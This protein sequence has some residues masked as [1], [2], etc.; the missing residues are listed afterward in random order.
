MRWLSYP[1][2][3]IALLA[4]SLMACDGDDVGPGAATPGQDSAGEDGAEGAPGDTSGP[5]DGATADGTST[6]ISA[7]GDSGPSLDALPVPD[8]MPPADVAPPD[9]GAATDVAAD[10][11]PDATADAS[12][13]ADSGVG[14]ADVGTPDA[15]TAVDTAT[16]PT[17]EWHGITPDDLAALLADEDVILI[18]VHIPF[19][20][21]IPGTDAHVPYTDTSALVAALGG[22][23]GA[24]A[25]LYCLTGPMS[26]KAVNDLVALGFWNLYDLIGG[27]NAWKAAGYEL[28]DTP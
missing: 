15:S 21:T 14:P 24:K 11:A 2:L 28:L 16:P 20:G 26:K 18:D 27:M 17:P 7:A 4:P 12:P 10:V 19:A 6:D 9:T 8:V 3:V 25:V 1:A 23:K 22:D 13:T 5:L